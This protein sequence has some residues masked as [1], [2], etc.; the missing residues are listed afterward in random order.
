MRTRNNHPL[1]DLG[2]PRVFIWLALDV[3]MTMRANVLKGYEVI[4]GTARCAGSP[5]FL[6]ARPRDILQDRRSESDADKRRGHGRVD[7]GFGHAHS[8]RT[9]TVTEKWQL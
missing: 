1:T 3:S 9:V 6:I 7:A 4:P 2:Q 5:E 8:N